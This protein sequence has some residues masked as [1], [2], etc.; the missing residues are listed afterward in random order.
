M[1]R[2][3]ERRARLDREELVF[4]LFGRAWSHDANRHPK[5][6]APGQVIASLPEDVRRKLACLTAADFQHRLPEEHDED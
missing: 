3:P 5:H 4:K 6:R 1:S 2:D